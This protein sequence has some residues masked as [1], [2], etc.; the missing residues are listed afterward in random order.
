VEDGEVRRRTRYAVLSGLE[1]TGFVPEDAHHLGYF[2]PQDPTLRLPE[3]VPYEWFARAATDQ[4][5]RHVLVL[6]VNEDALG[7]NPLRKLSSLVAIPRQEKS[8]SKHEARIR[9]V[10]PYSSDILFDM[11]KEV[12]PGNGSCLPGNPPAEQWRDRLNSM[13][14]YAYGATVDDEE[15]FK[16]V[17]H[18]GTPQDPQ[19]TTFS[20]IGVS[21]FTERLRRTMSLRAVSSRS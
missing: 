13:S 15:L 6:W 10:A 8:D 4:P 7:G 12:E 16:K 14:F 2:R 18:C 20:K 5:T 1:R 17:Q 11:A 9:I 21:T 19:S 3:V